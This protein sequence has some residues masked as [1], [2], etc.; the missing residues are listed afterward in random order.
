MKAIFT[1][2]ASAA[3]APAM[4]QYDYGVSGGGVLTS[5]WP[6][7]N[8]SPHEQVVLGDMGRTSFSAAVFYRERYSDFVD[9]GFDVSVAHRSFSVQYSTSGLGGGTTKT[10]RVE[11]D[12]LYIGVK[13][14]VRMDAKRSAVVRFGLMGGFRVGSVKNGSVRTW[15]AAGSY[16]YKNDVDLS[17]DFGGDLRLAFAATSACAL[18]A[19]A[20]RPSER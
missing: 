19:P 20:G 6:K 16:T 8:D 12:H 14:E 2:L 13:P 18:G 9:L 5:L 11:M 10:A 1:I 3:V 17:R 4:A 7:Y 15:S